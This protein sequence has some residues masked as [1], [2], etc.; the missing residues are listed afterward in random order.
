MPPSMRLLLLLLLVLGTAVA[1]LEARLVAISRTR[2]VV[3]SLTATERMPNREQVE[4]DAVPVPPRTSAV[5]EQPAF[6]SDFVSA[7]DIAILPERRIRGGFVLSP[8]VEQ[9]GAATNLV[10]TDG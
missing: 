1:A 3:V 10:F 2:P 9:L 4:L 7:S 6:E 5:V 8:E